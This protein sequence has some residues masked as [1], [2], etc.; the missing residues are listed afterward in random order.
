M[1]HLLQANA[2]EYLLKLRARAPPV[3]AWGVRAT[4]APALESASGTGDADGITS[5]VG[6]SGA[7]QEASS[8]SSSS[9]G[10][11]SNTSKPPSSP[12]SR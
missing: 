11:N 1:C 9:S 7:E 6:P 8:S 5:D 3:S 2:V 4:D 10:G 12:S